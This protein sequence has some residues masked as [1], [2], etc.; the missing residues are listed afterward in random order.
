[1]SMGNYPPPG[2][3]GSGFGGPAGGGEPPGGGG[4]WGGPPGGGYGPPPGGGGYGPPGGGG[5]PPGGGGW[6]SPPGGGGYGPPPGAG[7][8]PSPGGG[9][10]GGMTPYGG[11]GGVVQE[12]NSVLVLF[13]P[14]VTC[15]IYF[16]YWIYQTSEELRRATGDESI[17]PGTDLILTIVTCGLWGLFVEYRNAQ[18][19]HSILVAQNPNRK[20]QSQTILILNIAAFFVGITGL[21][22]MFMVQ[23]ELNQLARAGSTRA[24]PR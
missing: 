6:G 11:G 15:G 14:L 4:G 16:Y 1:M 24:L 10:P 3:G 19:V 22:A 23:E 17:N 7:W 2:G 8:P 13:L 21:I 9:A 5:G 12:R 20:D 18:K